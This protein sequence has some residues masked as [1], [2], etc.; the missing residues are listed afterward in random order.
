[1]RLSA[2]NV[3]LAYDRRVVVKDLDLAIP[4][5]KVTVVVG[6]NACGKSTLLRGLARLL[7]PTDGAVLLDGAQLHKLPTRQV[8]QRIGVL[9]QA[10]L[11]PDGITVGDLVARGRHPHQTWWRQWSAD[12]EAA[13]RWAM[14]RTDVTELAG[15]VVDELSGGQRQRVWIAVALAQ[16]TPILLLDEPTTFLD[17][18]HQIEVLDLI[19]ALQRDQDRTVVAVLHDLNHACRYADHLV[20]MRDGQIAAAGPPAE[21]VTADLVRD[22]FGIDCVITPCPVTGAPMVVPGRRPAPPQAKTTE[23]APPADTAEPAPPAKTAE[24]FVSAHSRTTKGEETQ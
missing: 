9:P 17:I 21:I 18:A 6:P 19:A 5:G 3:T 2:E 11:P 14:E 16:G 24:P 8:A 23:P 1:M 10:P 15:R 12:D 13:V 4:P 22:V 20:C 7:R